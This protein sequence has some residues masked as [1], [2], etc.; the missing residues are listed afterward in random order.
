MLFLCYLLIQ[1]LQKILINSIRMNVLME[2]GLIF[3]SFDRKEGLQIHRRTVTLMW[4]ERLTVR[5]DMCV[6]F[7][8]EDPVLLSGTTMH[9]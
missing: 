2:A 6:H 8:A 7:R 3:L 1:L 4:N 5:C 9:L